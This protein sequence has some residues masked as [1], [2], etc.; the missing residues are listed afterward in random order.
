VVACIAN[1]ASTGLASI[2]G[3]IHPI[4][5]NEPGGV[6]ITLGPAI[7][8]RHGRRVRVPLAPGSF[9]TLDVADVQP[10]APSTSVE[11]AGGGIL[12]Y[13]GERTTPVSR[14]ASI[15]VTI[16]TSGPRLLDVD[17]VLAIAASE[18]RFDQ[19]DDG[20]HPPRKDPDG[21]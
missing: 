2:A 8:G 15:S 14:D 12:A 4:D 13:D 11:L 19:A 20:A 17:R 5:R 10:L 7:P 1:P 9:A 21:H 18:R 6:L 16:E 3:R